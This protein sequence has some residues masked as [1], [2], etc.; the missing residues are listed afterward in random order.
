MKTDFFL[1]LIN[2]PGQDGS[3]IAINDKELLLAFNLVAEI[4]VT[5]IIKFAGYK[6]VN[7]EFNTK[8]SEEL[9]QQAIKAMFLADDDD[10][11]GFVP[12][13]YGC[14]GNYTKER[15]IAEMVGATN[16]Q[17]YHWIFSPL[18]IRERL[19]LYRDEKLLNDLEFIEL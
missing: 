9:G 12:E 5:T 14:N 16:A 17:K 10:K 19:D 7:Y 11:L 4:A 1:N 13:F 3:N 18:K 2:P 6:G 15:Y 8:L